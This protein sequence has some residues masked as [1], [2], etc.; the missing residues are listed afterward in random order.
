MTDA[1]SERPGADRRPHADAV[2]ARGRAADGPPV[3][4]PPP[5]APPSR[6]GGPVFVS[7]SSRDA[8]VATQFVTALEAAGVPCWVAPRDIPAAADYNAAIMDGLAAARLLVLIYSRH[9]VASDPVRREVE[10]ALHHQVPVLPVRL[11]GSPPSKALEY[12]IASAQWV[13]AFPPPADRHLDKVVAAVHRALGRA[14]S[15]PR[16]DPDAAPKY[17]G[18]YRILEPLG[19]GGMGTVYKAEQ[20]SPV[21]RV[22]A[23]KRIKPGFDSAEVVARFEAERQALA[24]MDHPHVAKVLDAGADDRGRPYFVMEYVP[25]VP[26]T[27]FA[28]DKKLTVRQRLALFT[29]ACD[30]IAHAHTK[31]ILHRDVK[32]GNVLAYTADGGKPAVKV[33]DFGI[34][35]A[36]TGDRLTDRTLHTS[37]GQAIGTYEAMSPEQADGSPDIDTRT[38]VYSLGVLLYELLTGS[39]PFDKATLAKAADAEVRR[40]IRE[41]EPPRPSTRLSGLAA[42][43]G[44]KVAVA[45]QAVLAALA[46]ELRSELEWI[47]LKAMRKERERR[48][49]SPLQLAE[50]C[51]RYLDGKPLIAAPESRLYRARK[52]ARRNRAVLTA[53]SAVALLLIGGMTYVYA[54]AAEQRRTGIARDEAGRQKVN[55]KEQEAEAKRQKGEADRQQAEA[56]RRLGDLYAYKGWSQI[57]AGEPFVALLWFVRALDA[58]AADTTEAEHARIRIGTTFTFAPRLL[59]IDGSA[60]SDAPKEGAGISRGRRLK[61]DGQ[62]VTII[63]A[64]TGESLVPPFAHFYPVNSATFSPD[65]RWIVT[66]SGNDLNREG[67]GWVWDATTGDTVSLLVH[68]GSVHSAAFNLDG[69]RVATASEDWSARVWDAATGEPITPPLWHKGGVRSAAFSPDGRR[70]V[71]ASADHTARVWDAVAGEAV[72]PPLRQEMGVDSA[73]F[74]ADGRRVI[75]VSGSHTARVWDTSIGQPNTRPLWH[76]GEIRSAVFSPDGRRA[77]TASAD[78]TA[79]VWDADTGDPV[80]PPLRHKAYVHSATFSPDG[81]R[82]ATASGDHTARV[83]DSTIG[84]PI[85]PPLE[86]EGEVYSAAFSPD[87]RQ[88]VT[89][90]DDHKARIWDVGPDGR[91]SNHLKAL[92]ELLA[93]QRLDAGDGLFPLTAEEW[94]SRWDLLRRKYP[95]QF[96]PRASA[97]RPASGLFAE[98]ATV[99]SP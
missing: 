89:A 7:H 3:L 19:A 77:V 64:V 65:G 57:D 36:L 26:I 82:V 93:V 72:T 49:A 30:A 45:R 24:R 59:D 56:R 42:E 34:A 55:V 17:I 20:R 25:G 92:V 38:D 58:V 5:P 66:A 47:P 33:I 41:V 18:P 79:R 32:P 60:L 88:L 43:A 84:Q 1:D 91:S 39:Q 70:V 13:D 27:Q 46:G 86:H 53:I 81:R 54:I 48:Y 67:A 87:G 14:S 61:V 4:G 16:P 12:M 98:P 35:K 22:V 96:R 31:S 29:Q 90:S 11:D 8:A 10:R 80:T 50:D 2:A 97:T 76:E 40:I 85:T 23:V 74:T 75:T 51:Q 21:K 99:P 37:R 69:R 78:H 94:Q 44:T 83:W 68:K 6:A 63:N 71:T 52:F 62:D 15:A 73:S 28:D 95:D 9:S